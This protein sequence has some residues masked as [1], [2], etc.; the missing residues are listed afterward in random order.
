MG[1]WGIAAV[2]GRSMH[3][4]LRDGDRLLVS[5]GRRVQPGDLVLVQLPGE[6]PLA[7]KRALRLE[8]GGWFVERDNPREGVDSWS[9]G[10]IATEAVMAVVV[11]RLAPRP[12]LFTAARRKHVEP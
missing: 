4:T 12:A 3:P 11:A 9:V 8:A 6:R 10:P 7:V 5:Y 1:R 2:S